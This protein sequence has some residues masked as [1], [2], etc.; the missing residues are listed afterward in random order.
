MSAGRKSINV[1]EGMMDLRNESTSVITQICK[2]HRKLCNQGN[3]IA[4]VN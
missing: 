1:S 4:L 3:L 2:L